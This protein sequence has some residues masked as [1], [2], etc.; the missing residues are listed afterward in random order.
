[1]TGAA[2][3]KARAAAVKSVGS[4]HRRCGHHGLHG[5]WLRGDDHQ[6]RRQQGGGPPRQLVQGHAGPRRS[7]SGGSGPGGHGPGGRAR[8]GRAGLPRPDTAGR[9]EVTARTGRVRRLI[10]LDRDG[11]TRA[12]TPGLTAVLRFRGEMPPTRSRGAVTRIST[13]SRADKRLDADRGMLT[14]PYAPTRRWR[15]PPRTCA[16]SAVTCSRW[17]LRQARRRRLSTHPAA[18]ARAPI[19]HSFGPR[20]LGGCRFRDDVRSVTVPGCVDGLTALNARFG[21]LALSDV[22]APAIRLAREGFPVSPTLAAASHALAPDVRA[23]AFGY[24]GALVP[25]R[26]VAVPG[27]ARALADVAGG[28]RA[29]FYEE[30]AGDALRTLG[31]GLFSVEDLATVQADWVDPL[32]LAAFGRR[33]WTI[34]HPTPRGISRCRARGSPIRSVFPE[35]PEDDSWAFILVEA[36]RQAAHD[37]I[38]VLHDG[39]DGGGCSHRT[40]WLRGPPPCAPTPAAVSPTPTAG[41]TRPTCARSTPSGPACR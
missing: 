6:G 22:F 12:A 3:D 30:A 2:A 41:A 33:L 17:S 35:D 32:S 5:P 27:V 21:R 36:A 39:A 23:T 1:M 13:M 25:G 31:A 37:R 10:V 19:L 18:R 20:A 29:S 34:P 24:P 7:R 38:A 4:G 16:A 8:A 9:T 14:P 26:R 28:G 11:R 15:S 40:G